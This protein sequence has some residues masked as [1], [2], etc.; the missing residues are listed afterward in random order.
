MISWDRLDWD[1]GHQMRPWYLP[2][3]WQLVLN[4]SVV[5]RIPLLAADFF[6]KPTNPLVVN[7]AR[8]SVPDIDLFAW[9]DRSMKAGTA[10]TENFEW[11]SRNTC[12]GPI[13][14]NPLAA[15]NVYLGRTPSLPPAENHIIAHFIPLEICL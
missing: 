6:E 8:L 2:R 1:W 15:Q 5:A 14:E 13:K 11:S 3:S 9:R 10:H 4:P 7:P 12:L